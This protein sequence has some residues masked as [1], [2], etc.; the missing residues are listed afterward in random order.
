MFK[1][2]LPKEYAFF[3]NFADHARIVQAASQE[4]LR[5]TRS[6]VDT[7]VGIQAIK[8]WEHE[9]DDITHRCIDALNRTFI[10][11]I[12]RPDILRL[13]KNM[14]DVLDCIDA[15]VIRMGL[16]DIRIMREEAIAMGEIL[17]RCSEEILQ[18]VIELRDL[19]NQESI[20]KRCMTIHHLE[21]EGD[22][23]LR[24]ALQRLFKEEDAVLIIKW[25]D[26]FERLEKSTDRADT[27]AVIIEGI[28]ISA[29]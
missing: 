28:V 10:T 5:L 4:L 17:L 22:Q 1:S 25:K 14:D 2:L 3:D 9:A 23:V 15:A 12:D 7:Q 16:Y 20:N 27:V 11:P 26:I 19:K 21:H 8:N 18:A 24:A 29:S 6:E 13:I